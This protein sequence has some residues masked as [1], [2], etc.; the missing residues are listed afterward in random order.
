MSSSTHFYP[1]GTAGSPWGEV[2]RAA[3]LAHVGTINRSYK[4]EV[5]AKI[6]PLKAT[7]DVVRIF[8]FTIPFLIS[9]L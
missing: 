5:I 3:W 7:F 1:I 6:L 4:E 8:L 9:C 2:E